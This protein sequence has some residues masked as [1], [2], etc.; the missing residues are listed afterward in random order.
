MGKL[1][2]NYSEIEY[3]ASFL[4]ERKDEKLQDHLDYQALLSLGFIKKGYNPVTKEPLSFLT[5][6][7]R[8]ELEFLLHD[9]SFKDQI[10]FFWNLYTN[11][12]HNWDK[13]HP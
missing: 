8:N 12:F 10:K 7:G 4:G 11:K 3:L 13:F 1:Y 2:V 6:R 9:L 5:D